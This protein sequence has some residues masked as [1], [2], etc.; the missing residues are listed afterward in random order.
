MGRKEF[1]GYKSEI[2]K[3][4]EQ[5]N[6]RGAMG[7]NWNFIEFAL[8]FFHSRCIKVIFSQNNSSGQITFFG[9]LS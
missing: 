6:N 7:Q 1:K 5:D 8:Q 4:Q 9:R 2:L 3:R